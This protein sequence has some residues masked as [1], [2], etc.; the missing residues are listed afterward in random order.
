MGYDRHMKRL[1]GLILL[2][3][4]VYVGYTRYTA[5]KQAPIMSESHAPQSLYLTTVSD[6]LGEMSN[7]LGASISNIVENGRDYVSEVTGGASEPIINQLVAKT[8]ETLKD[9]P[10]KEADKIKYEFCKGVV[11]EYESK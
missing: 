9:L 5:P 1:I 8:Q 11:T 4:I 6:K 10:K 7:V 3:G 2:A